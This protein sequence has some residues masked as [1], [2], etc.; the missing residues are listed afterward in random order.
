MPSEQQASDPAFDPSSDLQTSSTRSWVIQ[1]MKGK[2]R[3]LHL[4]MLP[5]E[6]EESSTNKS[7]R[8]A[9]RCVKGKPALKQHQQQN[10]EEKKLYTKDPA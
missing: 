8:A 7:E 1:N 9:W 2:P 10:R 3:V 4:T 5:G 6:E